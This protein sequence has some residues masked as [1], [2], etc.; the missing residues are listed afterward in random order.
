MGLR[1]VGSGC[2][3]RLMGGSIE[4][5]F[6]LEVVGTEVKPEKPG[7]SFEVLGDLLRRQ[8][9]E[10]GV[11][12]HVVRYEQ[13]EGDLGAR[14]LSHFLVDPLQGPSATRGSFRILTVYMTEERDGEQKGSTFFDLQSLHVCTC[15]QS[16]VG[17]AGEEQGFV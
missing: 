11:L 5:C 17:L 4:A 13:Y 7:G 16:S 10:K 9:G 1:V 12:R 14:G 3:E 2:G 6:H 15:G 8:A